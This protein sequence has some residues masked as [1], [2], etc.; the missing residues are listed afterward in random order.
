MFKFVNDDNVLVARV[1]ENDDT[2]NVE[3]IENTSTSCVIDALANFNK[4]E[5]DEFTIRVNINNERAIMRVT[6]IEDFCVL[7]EYEYTI[8]GTIE[9]IAY[10]FD[11][12]LNVHDIF[13]VDNEYDYED[14]YFENC[15][16]R[17]MTVTIVRDSNAD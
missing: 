5:R 8:E 12:L 10:A 15:R 4:G 2:H 14:E 6:H 9:Q 16:N 11:T 7:D 13:D 17:G 1:K 3:C